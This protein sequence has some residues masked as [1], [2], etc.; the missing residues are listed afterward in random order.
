MNLYSVWERELIFLRQI[1]RSL[2]CRIC[3]GA[4]GVF[5]YVVVSMSCRKH[6]WTYHF[7][8]RMHV[9]RFLSAGLMVMLGL[10]ERELRAIL[11]FLCS[12]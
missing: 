1:N 4:I 5:K 11:S 12:F 6:S 9:P 7:V 8:E 10:C 2:S 3:S